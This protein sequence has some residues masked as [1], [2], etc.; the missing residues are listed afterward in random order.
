MKSLKTIGIILFLLLS[1]L[2]EKNIAQPQKDVEIGKTIK[3]SS[4][5]LTEERDIFI[6]LPNNYN[7]STNEYP[8]LYLLDAETHFNYT[9]GVVQFLA[10]NNRMP[11]TIVIGIPNTKRN[12]DFTPTQVENI[13]GS[14]GADN[15]LKFLKEELFPYVEK[16]YRTQPYRILAGHSLCGMF[17]FYTLFTQP[18][19]FNSYIALSP[20][21]IFNNNYLVD[22]AAVNLPKFSSLNKFIYF[23]AGSLEQQ[24]LLTTMEKFNEILKTKAPKDLIWKYK[25]LENEDHGSL[26]LLTLYDGLK[27]IFADWNLSNDVAIKG[28]DAILDHY[29]KLSN[30]Y[31]YKIFPSEINLNA[32]GYY[33]LQRQDY[34]QAI[35]VFKKNV[36]LYSASANVYDSLGEA[37]E[38]SNQPEL[39]KENYEKAYI[40]AK[41]V[42]HQNTQIYKTNFERLQQQL[43]KK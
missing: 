7:N 28:L 31:G 22:Y 30:K 23:T 34:E 13:P 42:S 32:I 19:L 6:Y 26:V 27:L 29:K 12:R 33:F 14:G 10:G 18:G 41:A 8:V 21:V 2:A 43:D 20:W 5:I 39:A 15:F 40:A 25:L 3:L 1:M 36:E 24:D 16:N 38:K 9:A 17:T 4:N 11:E 37:F 35:K